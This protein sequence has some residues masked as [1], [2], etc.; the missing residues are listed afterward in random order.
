MSLSAKLIKR[1]ARLDDLYDHAGRCLVCLTRKDVWSIQGE[2]R[3]LYLC[4][5]CADDVVIEILQRGAMLRDYMLKVKAYRIKQKRRSI[6][7]A[8]LARR[9]NWK[10]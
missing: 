7:Y 3:V 1:R 4:S 9:F 10:F 5:D 8:R 2:A 6:L